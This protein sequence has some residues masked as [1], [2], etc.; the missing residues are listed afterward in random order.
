MSLTGKREISEGCMCGHNR[1]ALL[2]GEPVELACPQYPESIPIV[3][4]SPVEVMALTRRIWVVFSPLLFAVDKATQSQSCGALL[5]ARSS[6]VHPSSSTSPHWLGSSV[7]TK[8]GRA[9]AFFP[10]TQRSSA[11]WQTPKV[12]Q[13]PRVLIRSW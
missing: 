13:M 5:F 8:A 9:S 10:L 11:S 2:A 1:A 7:S 12:R 4:G 6:R 3:I